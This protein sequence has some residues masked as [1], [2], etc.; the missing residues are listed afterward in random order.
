M[1]SSAI[2]HFTDPFTY[3]SA[4]PAAQLEFLP[5]KNGSFCVEL[6][7]ITLDRLW[8]ERGKESLPRISHGVISPQRVLVNF[9]TDA[10]QP[11]W[12]H[13]GTNA[14]PGEI[15]VND[16]N[17]MH[18]Q[19]RASS[20]WGAMSLTLDDLAAA[21]T[22]LVGHPVMRPSVTVVIKPSPALMSRLLAL[23]KAAVQLAR[24]AP[25]I[26]TNPQ[27]ARALENEL[28][29]AMVM[30]LTE[31]IQVKRS[32][33]T[34]RHSMLMGRLEEFLSEHES[35]ALY[36]AD[37]CT[38][39][40][41]SE[42]TLRAICQEHLG[43][44]LIRYLRLRRM[45]LVRRALLQA[46]PGLSTVTRIAANYGFW[47]LGRFSVEYRARFGETPLATLRRPPIHDKFIR[48]PSEFA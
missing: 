46:A 17:E 31:N 23:N 13:C 47:E 18:R 35:G 27:V 1:A 20:R 5:T 30:C 42:R 40:G 6:T 32:A 41:A 14:S 38:A 16:Q 11:E 36:V 34:Q 19:T 7:K 22:A 29:H 37:I 4:L 26:L 25:D 8:I 33:G 24:T 9:L 3:Q 21:G 10:N 43:M 12:R 48:A 44:G 15:V 39:I 45:H 28:T 2:H